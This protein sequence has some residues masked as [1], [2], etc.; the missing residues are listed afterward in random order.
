MKRPDASMELLREIST[1]ALDPDY[2]DTTKP[3][4]NPRVMALAVLLVTAV[5]AVAGLTTA[6]ESGES[7]EVREELLTR[8]SAQEEQISA[9]EGEVAQLQSEVAKLRQDQL[10]DPQLREALSAAE[11]Q[12]GAV[13]VVGPG[14]IVVADDASSGAQN[15]QVV[16]DTDL[17]QLVNGLWEAGAEAIAINGHRITALTPIRSAGS[18]ITVDYVS[19]SPPYRIEAI[20]DPNQL[21]AQYGQTAG[22]AWWQFIANNYAI[23]YEI[24]LSEGDLE[25]AGDA[26]IALRYAEE[27]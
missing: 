24:S 1:T 21:L 14:L 17:T 27:G 25:L 6:E 15:H 2:L 8:I 12:V 20:G 3:R 9:L 26:G 16:Y 18:A 7:A 23:Q 13:P 11:L 22:A 4:S 5:I 10:T 19:L